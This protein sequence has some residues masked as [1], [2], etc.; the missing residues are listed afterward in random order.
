MEKLKAFLNKL[1]KRITDSFFLKSVF[2]LSAGVFIS[3]AINFLGTPLISRIYTPVAMGDYASITASSNVIINLVTLGMLT[4]LILPQNDGESRKLCKLV[5]GSS[6]LL[7][8]LFV[9]FLYVIRSSYRLFVTEGASYEVS[10][11]ILWLYVNAGNLYSVYYAYANRKRLYRLMFWNP[12]IATGINVLASVILGLMGFGFLGYAFARVL[13]SLV[14]TLHLVMHHVN[15]LRKDPEF[16]LSYGRVLKKY[17]RFPLYQMP[18]SLVSTLGGQIL[19]WI[20]Q[21]VYGSATLGMYSMTTRILSQPS[22]LLAGPVNRVFFQE[23]SQ[24]YARGENIG[25]FALRVL[26]SNIKIAIIPILIIVIFGRY[27]FSIFL[28]STWETA[29]VYASILGIYFLIQFCAAC[30]SGANLIIEKNHWTFFQAIANLIVQGMLYILFGYFFSVSIYV[31][32]MVFSVI[33]ILENAIY[34]GIFF[35]F[36]GINMKRY[37]LF[38]AKYIMIPLIIIYVVFGFIHPEM[39]GAL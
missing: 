18:A 30:L 16:T 21:G 32:L 35:H 15:P 37:G 10:L 6:I 34:L 19:V 38:L 24:R 29:G 23:A 8:S 4:A 39:F 28:G 3:Q 13:S 36:F 9:L 27:I 12:I 26:E 7:S 11:V 25:E 14:N 17:R 1:Y 31:F 33:L 5:C 20:I 22:V 2:T